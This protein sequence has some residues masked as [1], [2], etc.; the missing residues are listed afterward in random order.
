MRWLGWEDP[1]TA[2]PL[3]PA[4]APLL[5]RI[6]PAGSAWSPRE[7]GALGRAAPCCSVAVR[8]AADLGGATSP[9]CCGRWTSKRR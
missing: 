8:A 2:A 4:A 1:P 6:Q 5:L 7:S 3:A 9:A